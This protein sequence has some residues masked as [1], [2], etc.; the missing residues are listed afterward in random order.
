MSMKMYTVSAI[1]SLHEGRVV[2]DAKQARRRRHNIKL[3]EGDLYEI[4]K[5]VQFK[6]GEMIGLDEATLK[7]VHLVNL[8]PV[9]DST[10]ALDDGDNSDA[11]EQS[12]G[13]NE[14][15]GDSDGQG[16]DGEL[17]KMHYK[18]IQK[19]VEAKGGV[20]KNKV[21]GIEFLRSLQGGDNSDAGEQSK[22]VSDTGEQPK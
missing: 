19:L 7:K 4:I 5:P 9:G 8:A 15:D 18:E 12:V 11:G 10:T 2:L 6:I 22:E 1:T 3:I 17:E 16:S 20:W 21:K 13:G 14:G